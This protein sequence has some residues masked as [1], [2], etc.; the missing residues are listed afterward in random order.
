MNAEKSIQP[1][2][3][4]PEDSTALRATLRELAADLPGTLAKLR[5]EVQRQYRDAEQSVVR[6][7]L[8]EPR[9]HS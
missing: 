8:D 7:R 6:A 5:P 9:F 1:D 4:S 3:L 2:E